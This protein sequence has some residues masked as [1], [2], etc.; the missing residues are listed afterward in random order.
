MPIHPDDFDA[1]LP[2]GIEEQTRLVLANLNAVLSHAGYSFEEVIVVRAYL[3]D[4]KR[5]YGR[6]N[7]VYETY[8]KRDR[9]PARTTVG[10]TGLAREALV[11]ID[12]ICRKG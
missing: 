11:E 8:F 10:V 3:C 7:A 9:L 4:F 6:F 2:E 12:M 5:D 1:P